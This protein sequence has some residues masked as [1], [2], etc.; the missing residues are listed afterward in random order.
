MPRALL[1]LGANLG[2]RRENLRQA[3]RRLGAKCRVTAVSSLYQSPALVP[4][5]D[6]PGPDFLNAVCEVE[7]E[8]APQELRAFVKDIEAVIGRTPAP[9]WSARVI[10]IDILLYGE[11]VM[12][13]AD[14][15][16]PHAAMTERNFVMVPLAEIAPDAV[17]PPLGKTIAELTEDVDV[18]GLEH[19]DGPEW[20]ADAG[21]TR[22]TRRNMAPET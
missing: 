13:D 20:A 2:D 16:V 9:R 4:P 5:G 1:G 14:L 22:P 19:V 12:R 6:P 7:T 18:A 21:S 11:A 15:V 10:D 8:L 17:H 3:L